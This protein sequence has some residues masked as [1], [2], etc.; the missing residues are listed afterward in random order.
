MRKIALSFLTAGVVL[1]LAWT[2]VWMRPR[3]AHG[4]AKPGYGFAAVPGEKGGWNLTGPHQVV[5]GWPKP[6]LQLPGHEKWGWGAVEGVSA[7]SP[8]R[9]FIAQRG[10]QP[11]LTRPAGVPLPQFGPSLSFPVAQKFRPRPGANPDF[12]AGKPPQNPDAFLR[13]VER[14]DRPAPV[15]HSAPVTPRVEQP[16][17]NREP[18][19]ERPQSKEP[20][21][22]K[23]GEDKQ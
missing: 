5:S 3:A 1:V 16:A 7:E 23:K 21:R 11:A 20:K 14:P 8:D 18:R 4:Q 12:L 6:M 22:E 13:R 9:I 19:R 15:E 17:P 10:E 2:L